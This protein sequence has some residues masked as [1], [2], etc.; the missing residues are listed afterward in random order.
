MK[1]KK[2]KYE[3]LIVLFLVI[4]VFFVYPKVSPYISHKLKVESDNLFVSGYYYSINMDQLTRLEVDSDKVIMTGF[5]IT[6]LKQSDKYKVVRDI[7]TE[8]LPILEQDSTWKLLD[9]SESKGNYTLRIFENRLSND[10]IRIYLPFWNSN[11]NWYAFKLKNERDL[12][13]LSSANFKQ[14]E[15]V[16]LG[17]ILVKKKY[18]VR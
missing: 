14:N 7:P 10:R 16:Y 2:Y 15:D 5:D 1:L 6:F 4:M 18:L 13:I 8:Y 11:P 9:K 3:I 17:F 12:F